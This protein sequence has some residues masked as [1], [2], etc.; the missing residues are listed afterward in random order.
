[1]DDID[2]VVSG[3]LDDYHREPY[4]QKLDRNDVEFLIGATMY[5]TNGEYTP[6]QIENELLRQIDGI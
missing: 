3:V 2:T 4:A 5:R 6:R 1:M